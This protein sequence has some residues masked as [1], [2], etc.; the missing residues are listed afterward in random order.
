MFYNAVMKLFVFHWVIGY[1][2]SAAVI[3]C[4]RTQHTAV[5]SA[6][7]KIS[8]AASGVARAPWDR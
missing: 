6:T 8:D 4:D 1:T 2:N 3:D 5:G 7:T